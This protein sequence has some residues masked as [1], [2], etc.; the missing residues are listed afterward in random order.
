LFR[1]PAFALLFAITAIEG[2]ISGLVI[3][4]GKYDLNSC[5]R[6]REHGIFFTD[7]NL[8]EGKVNAMT[9]K[10]FTAAEIRKKRLQK[11]ETDGGQALDL[12]SIIEAKLVSLGYSQESLE[13]MDSE[14]LNNL[15]AEVFG[16]ALEEWSTSVLNISADAAIE[17]LLGVAESF[18]E[19]FTEKFTESF[20]V[21]CQSDDEK[22]PERILLQEKHILASYYFQPSVIFYK[23]EGQPLPEILSKGNYSCISREEELHFSINE[24]GQIDGEAEHIEFV[25]PLGKVI[26]KYWFDNGFFVKEEHSDDRGIIRESFVT[27]G[28]ATLITY[29]YR[30]EDN[31]KVKTSEK[32]FTAYND[33]LITTQYYDTGEAFRDYKDGIVTDYDKEGRIISKEFHNDPVYKWVIEVYDENGNVTKTLK[34]DKRE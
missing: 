20:T 6:D 13:K 28:I 19:G 27:D 12:E 21:G 2:H 4:L 1:A 33:N 22:E 15:L 24:N 9:E 14:A 26:T 5:G 31:A 16:S 34:G 18:E 7:L 23:H 10:E 8:K 29:D 11:K 3:N 17:T 32:M 25:T 30:F